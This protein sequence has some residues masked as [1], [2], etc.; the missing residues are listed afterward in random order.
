MSRVIHARL[1]E[2]TDS[3]RAKL[4][5]QLGWSDSQ[6]VR[7]G[8][9]TLSNVMKSN[10]SRKIFGQGRFESGLEDLGSNKKHLKEFGE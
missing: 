5:Q 4:Q 10:R 8:I 3:L 6:I 2:L 1:D 7:E 9:K